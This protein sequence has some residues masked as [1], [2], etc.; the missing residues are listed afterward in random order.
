MAGVGGFADI[1]S[2]AR[3][4]VFSGNFTAGSRDISLAEGRVEIHRDGKIP[5]FVDRVSA[6]VGIPVWATSWGPGR[7]QTIV[8]KDPFSS[9]VQR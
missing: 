6:L 9:P 8:T 5:K 4:I 7:L 3:S 1:T 2:A